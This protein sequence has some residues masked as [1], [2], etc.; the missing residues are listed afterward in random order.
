M[1][2]ALTAVGCLPKS[3]REELPPVF[4][5]S[6]LKTRTTC[7]ALTGCRSSLR[8]GGH[9]EAAPDREGTPSACQ[10]APCCSG[11]LGPHSH[12]WLHTE[13]RGPRTGS[14]Q[15]FNRTPT[16]PNAP[17][18]AS[19]GAQHGS[20]PR[21]YESIRAASV[22]TLTTH[23]TGPGYP[24]LLLA[25]GAWLPGSAQSTCWRPSAGL[26][27]CKEATVPAC[28]CPHVGPAGLLGWPVRPAASC[29]MPRLRKGETGPG[30]VLGLRNDQ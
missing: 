28:R 21:L 11:H 22:G 20:R 2:E 19:S 7:P 5:S 3:P 1:D 27:G 13:P 6:H 24:E 29:Q 15:H 10:Q 12:A 18:P 25:Q 14:S 4:P 16:R 23:H 17:A 9:L 8:P 26:L 30:T